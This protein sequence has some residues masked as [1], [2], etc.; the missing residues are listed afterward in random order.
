MNPAIFKAYDIR[1]VYPKDIDEENIGDIMKAIYSLFVEDLPNK[2]INVV[3][4]RDM[5]LSAPA[6]FEKAK[7]AL[8]E[9]G[10]MVF[11][12]GLTST[13]TMYYAVFK[14]RADAGIQLTASHNP[15]EYSGAKFLRRQGNRALKVSKNTGMEEVKKR[16]IEKDFITAATPG[17]VIAKPDI[18][19]EEVSD[20]LAAV[21]PP[22]KRR[23]KIVADPA[24]GMGALFLKEIARQYP[25]D[26]VG[27][28]FELDGSFP[29]HQPD[30]LQFDLLKDLQQKVMAEKAD[31]GIAPDGDGDRVF[32]VDEKGQII[33]ATMITSLISKEILAKKSG[34]KIVVDIRYTINAKNVIEK[35]GGLMS[36]CPVGHALITK[37]LND[38]NA[39]FAGESSGHFYFQET[40][41]AESSI[42]AIFYVL[43]AIQEENKPISKIIGRF[44]TSIESGEFNFILP[45]ATDPKQ[46]LE[47]V[48]KDYK[49]Q[50]SWLDG[51][52]IDFPDWRLNI[53]TSN[54]EPLLRLN[55]EG[56]TKELVNGKLEQ[57]RSKIIGLGGKPKG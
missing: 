32:F 51:L 31:L 55:I 4:G 49:G 1:G 52:A 25:V 27:M 45:D 30:P 35:Y 47:T 43:K 46:L 29:A 54:T 11:D 36:V 13:P 57:L 19:K 34:A 16:A 17:K 26:L 20:A 50:I 53:R 8:V 10:A 9:A 23:L 2:N 14:T 48:A 38:E 40:G 6:L 24:N 42:R 3:F 22:N 12:I 56:Q 44:Q 18:L 21:S 39:I 15:K 7:Q 41:G 33:P 5:R 37:Q 28:N